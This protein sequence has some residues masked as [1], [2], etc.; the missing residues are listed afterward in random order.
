MSDEEE[1]TLSDNNICNEIIDGEQD[2]VNVTCNY[3]NKNPPLR[4]RYVMIR[5]KD[6]AYDRNFLN[7][8]EVE[9]LSCPPG[10]WAT[11]LVLLDLIVPTPVTGV[12]M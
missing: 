5:R 10:R 9:V 6:N 12:K 1:V 7:F 4:G 3:K 2:V 11:I 8:C